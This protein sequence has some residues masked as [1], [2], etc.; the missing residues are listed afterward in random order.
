LDLPEVTH[1]NRLCQL[2]S[3]TMR[4]YRDLEKNF[5]A[6]V[7]AGTIVAANA[8]TKLLRLQQCTSGFVS[9]KDDLDETFVQE[10]GTEKETLL[11]DMLTDINRPAVVFCRFKRDLAAVERV[12]ERLKRNYGELSGKRRDLTDHAEMLPETEVMGVQIAAGG[13]GVDLTKASYGFYYS[14]GFSL[15]DFQQSIARLHRP[16]QSH[17][18][19]FY[20]LIAS[21][22]VDEK[23]YKAL[24]DK[25]EVI[26]SVIRDYEN[27]ECSKLLS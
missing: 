11:E 23:I 4:V 24:N 15:G 19:F 12:A 14:V 18:V 21:G 25:T 10:L 22:T 26:D 3:K 5:I 2:D 16:G 9:G 13:V 1:D 6:E 20:N 17:P 8:L 27:A 7:E